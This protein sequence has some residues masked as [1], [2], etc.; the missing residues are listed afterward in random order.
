MISFKF[1]VILLKIGFVIFGDIIYKKD[2]DVL[3]AP[4]V[5]DFP[6]YVD[7][8]ILYGPMDSLRGTSFQ[9]FTV[10]FDYNRYP[11]LTLPCGISS[12][13]MPIGLQ[14]IGHPM[15]EALICALGAAYET[16]TQWNSIHPNI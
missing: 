10:P 5:I 11:T 8:S 12:D 4:C 6:H 15:T 9:K 13:G 1:L 2:V 7:D 14:I 16:S 3:I